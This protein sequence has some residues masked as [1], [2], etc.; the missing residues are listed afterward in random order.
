MQ[1]NINQSNIE[2]TCIFGIDDKIKLN[3]G[4]NVYQ[5]IGSYPSENGCM[6]HLQCIEFYE[7][8]DLGDGIGIYGHDHQIWISNFFD[9]KFKMA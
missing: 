6:Y 4:N 3:D 7:F 9:Y 2:N 8:E 5:I 1:S